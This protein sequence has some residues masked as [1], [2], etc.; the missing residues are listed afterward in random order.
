M[1]QMLVECFWCGLTTFER[2]RRKE[3]DSDSWREWGGE[4]QQQL[5]RVR[6]R[7]SQWVHGT[8][9]ISHKQ[10][11][12]SVT[13]FLLC[14]CCWHVACCQRQ[15]ESNCGKQLEQIWVLEM[16]HVSHCCCCCCCHK[17]IYSQLGPNK[18]AQVKPSCGRF[19][20]KFFITSRGH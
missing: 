4:R 14:C 12:C 3:R 13:F 7:A 17:L 6:G 16:T 2:G 11:M 1:W 8:W 10:V 20:P 15:I 18:F 19:V 5:K 9:L